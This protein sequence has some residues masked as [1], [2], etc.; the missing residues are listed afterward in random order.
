MTIPEVRYTGLISVAAAKHGVKL[1]AESRSNPVLSARQL[2]AAQG[3]VNSALIAG[4]RF[5]LER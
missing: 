2:V 3:I 1:F 4:G 5:P